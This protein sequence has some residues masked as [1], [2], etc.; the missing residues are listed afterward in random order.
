[1]GHIITKKWMPET[2]ACECC[3]GRAWSIQ[4]IDGF[5]KVWSVKCSGCGNT[6]PA[7]LSDRE[8]LLAWNRA[9]HLGSS[10]T[11]A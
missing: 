10:T 2:K 6:S 4:H 3:G 11:A 5:L 8:A 1:M 7:Y 9:H